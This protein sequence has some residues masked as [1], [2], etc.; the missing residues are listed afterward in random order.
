MSSAKIS[1]SGPNGMRAIDARRRA[2]LEGDGVVLEERLARARGQHRDAFFLVRRL[3]AEH[4]RRIPVVADFV[5]VPHRHLPDLGGKAP[6]MFVETVVEMVAA[7]LVER[8]GHFALGRRHHVPPHAAIVQL[9]RFLQRLIGVDRVADVE[10]Q[11]GRGGAH[12]L[13][14]P[15][16][17]ASGVDAPALAAGIG[18]PRDAHRPSGGRRGLQ[19]PGFGFTHDA[20][21]VRIFEPHAIEDVLSG[22]QVAQGDARGESGRGCR[23]VAPDP[24][25]VRERIRRG[26]FDRHASGAIDMRPDDRSTRRRVA[27]RH[28]VIN[29][30]PH[31]IG[32]DD[33]RRL[34]RE[35]AQRR[36]GH[37][38]A[39]RTRKKCRRFIRRHL[40]HL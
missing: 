29:S 14:Q 12:G 33:R 20:R 8:L 27:R 18:G 16:A 23:D 1:T 4:L 31:A 6:V 19:M 9:H 32:R 40:P 17:A 26:V 25:C 22:R 21:V 13:E 39:R 2:A 11:I 36:G 10:E 24:A 7:E 3:R 35:P 30:R 5:V 37:Q 34:L 28:T 15:H 38:A